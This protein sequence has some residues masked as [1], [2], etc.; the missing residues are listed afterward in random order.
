MNKKLGL[1]S[2]LLV[3]QLVLVAVALMIPLGDDDSAPQ[4]LAFTPD[5][6][7]RLDIHDGSEE[8]VI[9]SA[10]SGWRV[11]D[12][13]ADADKVSDIL[14]KL[15]GIDAPWPVATSSASAA[16]FEVSAE[17]YQRRV[18]LYSAG[19]Q[20]AEVFLG[21]SPGYERVHARRSDSDEV[22]S[23]PLSNY[24]LSTDVDSWMDKTVLAMDAPPTRIELHNL[25][26]EKTELLESVD[27]GWLYNGAAADQDAAGIYANRF[28]SL[29]VL[30]LA[31]PA[32]EGAEA[33]T[34]I[35]KLQVSNDTEQSMLVISRQGEEDD[36]F[37]TVQDTDVSYRLA[38]YIAEQLL[39]TDAD[40]TVQDED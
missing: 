33:P 28:T 6:I 19:E 11:A 9:R 29:R 23:V 2:A 37:I 21:T 35:G 1:L 15:A 24:E 17:D 16:R 32:V 14:E 38:T 34:A 26:A 40:F 18:R 7:D 20:I 12:I 3:V 25:M 39:M 4:L 5:K 22:F 31:S 10:A 8:V 30:G 36:Y 27:E 13:Q